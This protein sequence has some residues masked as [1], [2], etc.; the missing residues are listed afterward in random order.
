LRLSAIPPFLALLLTSCALFEPTASS[1]FE[2]APNSPTKTLFSCAETAISALEK[3]N[4]HWQATTTSQDLQH[5]LFETNNFKEI[6]I[7]GIRTQIK[8]DE[9]TGIGSIKIKASGAYFVDL[10]ADQALAELNS[11]IIQCMVP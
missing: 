2:I 4:P 5:G 10:G 9:P 6:N 3:Q 11:S 8:Y 1:S 7:T